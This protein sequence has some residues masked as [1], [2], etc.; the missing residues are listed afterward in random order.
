MS[1]LAPWGLLLPAYYPPARLTQKKRVQSDR[2]KYRMSRNNEAMGLDLDVICIHPGGSTYSTWYMYN[3][4]APCIAASYRRCTLYDSKKLALWFYGENLADRYW[5]QKI[6][7]SNY[8]SKW[9]SSA[10]PGSRI[11]RDASLSTSMLLFGRSIVKAKHASV[12]KDLICEY[13]SD[14][15]YQN[16][17]LLHHCSLKWV[18]L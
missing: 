4:Q 7:T 3:L 13:L 12:R 9:K 1:L 10:V 14:R 2:G 5:I 18:A 17:K 11:D 15:H 16:L 6:L 8:F